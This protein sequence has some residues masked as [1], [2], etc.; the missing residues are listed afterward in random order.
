M[1]GGPGVP[2]FITPFCAPVRADRRQV[3]QSFDPARDS[4]QADGSVQAV[5]GFDAFE[6]ET[7]LRLAR[8]ASYKDSEGSGH[9]ERVGR[10]S[11]LIADALGMPSVMVERI[12]LAAPLHDLGNLAIPETILFKDDA[13]SLEE[14]DLIK[15]HTTIGAGLL[16]D[17]R[18]TILMMG[19]EIAR[20]HHEN[21]DGTGYAPGVASD[22]IPLAARIVRV[23][24]TYD[25]MMHAR[26]FRAPWQ[27]EEAV[28]FV[29]AQGERRFDPVVVKAFLQVDAN[30]DLDRDP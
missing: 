7:A 11:A 10:L 12:R 1:L 22:D 30:G 28:D 23:A 2:H 29:T 4:R 27:R 16:A 17:T 24:D 20:Y 6:V 8:L 15:T 13:L 26:P 18:S 21:W 3:T 19:A 9:V 25:S 14:L 5:S